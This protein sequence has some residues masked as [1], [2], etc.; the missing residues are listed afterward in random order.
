MKLQG[1]EASIAICE[2]GKTKKLEEFK[3]EHDGERHCS[4]HICSVDGARFHVIVRNSLTSKMARMTLSLDGKVLRDSWFFHDLRVQTW[5]LNGVYVDF[6][7]KA[8][9]QFSKVEPIEASSSR[10]EGAQSLGT[11]EVKLFHVRRKSFTTSAPTS[12][13]KL[14]EPTAVDEKALK[15]R[16]KA[17]KV[18]LSHHIRFGESE[19]AAPRPQGV[20]CDDV[21]PIPIAT[22]K[23]T[24][25]SREVLEAC[26]IVPSALTDSE[27]VA[28]ELRQDNKE[29][30]QRNEELN[31]RL[32]RMERQLKL[33]RPRDASGSSQGECIDLTQDDDDDD[34]DDDDGDGRGNG[35]GDA[36]DTDRASSPGDS[37]PAKRARTSATLT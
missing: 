18:P 7:E 21:S 6:R 27:D 32:V 14:A 25:A 20:P 5:E 15:E 8:P 13:E 37:R 16:K 35:H 10:I 33:E 31:R 12:F 34:D 19:V 28:R 9:F 23:Y 17:Q 1:F 11:I 36:V 4:A 24:Y 2:D 3:V 29:L 26:G 30:R 22:F